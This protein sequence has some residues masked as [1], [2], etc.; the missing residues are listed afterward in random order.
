MSLLKVQSARG[1]S[2]AAPLGSNLFSLVVRASW[3]CLLSLQELLFYSCMYPSLPLLLDFSATLSYC[4]S[5][6]F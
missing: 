2:L 6:G 4:C 5:V 1:N 3:R